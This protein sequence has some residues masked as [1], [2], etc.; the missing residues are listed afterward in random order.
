MEVTMNKLLSAL[1]GVAL[2]ASPLAASA[3]G[4]HGGHGFGGHA[5]SGPAFRGGFHGGFGG[6]GFAPGFRGR[7]AVGAFLPGLYWD[8]YLND[9]YDYG[10][11]AAPFGYHWVYVDGEALLIQNGTGAVVQVAP[12]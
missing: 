2:L 6:R 7:W 1:A 8:A 11:S 9:P 4:V 3:Q 5:V 12:L 10:L